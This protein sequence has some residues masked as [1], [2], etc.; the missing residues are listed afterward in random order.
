MDDKKTNLVNKGIAPFYEPRVSE[1]LLESVS[2]NRF[3]AARDYKS[4]I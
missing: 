1:L 3:I 4:G 2:D